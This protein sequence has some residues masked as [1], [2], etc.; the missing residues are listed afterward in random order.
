MLKEMRERA[1]M[2]QAELSTEVGIPVRTISYWENGRALG[3]SAE[4]LRKVATA[5]GCTID[6]IVEGEERREEGK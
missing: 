3:M 6:E 1:G 4:N 2:T 5:L